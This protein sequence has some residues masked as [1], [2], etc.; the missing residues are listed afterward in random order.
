MSRKRKKPAGFSKF[1]SFLICLCLAVFGGA[2]LKNSSFF[3]QNAPASYPSLDL[4]ELPQYEGA[5]YA[6]IQENDPDFSPSD[7]STQ[8]FETY[9]PLD[10]LGR[11]GTAYA[12]IGT[13]LMPTEDRGNISEIHPSGWHSTTYEGIDGE[14]LYNRCHLIAFQLSGEN[15]NERNLITGTRYMN[16][17]GMLPFEEKVGD[18]VRETRNHV[19]YR[20]TPIFKGNNLVADGVHMEAESVEDQGKGIR[21]NV[22]IFNVQPGIEINYATGDSHPAGTG[23]AVSSQSISPGAPLQES[24]SYILNTFSKKFHL[25]SCE[26]VA[27]MNPANKKEYSGS[28]DDLIRKGYSPCQSCCP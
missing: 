27:S 15:A 4:Q 24:G 21:F 13:D 22:Y 18:Y 6:V 14:K 1:L 28:R 3:P 19:L 8:S 12:N 5:P 7:F 11:C 26:G 20:V 2:E 9:S 16:T 25:P 23:T 17:E 10:S